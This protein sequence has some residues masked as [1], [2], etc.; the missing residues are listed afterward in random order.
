MERKLMSE[1]LKWKAKSGRKPLL[2]EG[3]RQVGKTYLLKDF[4]KQNFKNAA[5]INLQNIS[6]KN[7]FLFE[8]LLN[9]SPEKCVK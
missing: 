2:L 1:P 9:G 8:H 4:G 7:I 5:Y 6:L 3:A